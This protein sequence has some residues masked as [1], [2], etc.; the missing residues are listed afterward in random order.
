VF[1]ETGLVSGT[2]VDDRGIA[3]GSMGLA[4][5]DYNLDAEPDI[6]VT[7]YENETFALYRNEKHGN[8]VCVS[9][10]SGITALGGL[11]VGFGTVAADLDW[12]GDEDIAIANGHVMYHTAR[13][14][15]PQQAI[16]MRNDGSGRFARAAFAADSYFSQG[17]WGRG[18][19]QAD[20]D[21]DGDIDLVFSNTNEPAAI[22]VNETPALG[23]SLAVRLIGTRSNRTAI[24][25]RLTLQ[26]TAGRFERYVSGGGS[27][28]SQSDYRQVWGLPEGA[29]VERLTIYWPSGVEQEVVGEAFE[30]PMT[31]VEPTVSMRR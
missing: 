26:T 10:A 21:A 29:R 4:V 8:F 5:F 7:N 28:L 24:G 22:V 17:R 11:Y 6:W 19:A 20:L 2:A 25:A 1:E 9:D 27:Y 30:S 31:I 12:D 23:R 15:G 18:L 14:P 13:T 16:V 3:N